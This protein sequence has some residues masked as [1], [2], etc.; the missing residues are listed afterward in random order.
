MLYNNSHLWISQL[1]ES[2]FTVTLIMT[3][4]AQNETKKHKKN[5]RQLYIGKN[6]L[7]IG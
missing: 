4:Q 3:L 2:S 1:E 5:L 6:R 7:N